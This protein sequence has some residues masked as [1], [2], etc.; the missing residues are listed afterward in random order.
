M[1]IRYCA[2]TRI[3]SN[4]LVRM[5]HWAPAAFDW[6]AAFRDPSVWE[7][8]DRFRPERWLAPPAS[9]EA[10]RAAAQAYLPFLAGPRNC[11]G[12]KLAMQARGD[13][14][15]RW[16]PARPPR[17]VK[18]DH[19]DLNLIIGYFAQLHRRRRSVCGWRRRFLF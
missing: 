13:S 15:A 6:E 8:P 2:R 9:E 14:G 5:G 11:I 19:S 12:Q 17:L 18:V 4:P 7:D 1:A 16:T 3:A 10:R